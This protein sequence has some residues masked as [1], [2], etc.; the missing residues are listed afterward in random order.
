MKWGGTP[1]R[2]EAALSLL[3]FAI[4]MVLAGLV[5]AAAANATVCRDHQLTCWKKA[6]R[7]LDAG[8]RAYVKQVEWC[9]SR[10]RNIHSADGVHHGRMQ[11]NLQTARAAGFARDPHLT[12]KFQQRVR[13]YRFAQRYGWSHWSCAS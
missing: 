10:A 7:S 2:R 8:T 13:A 3:A 1:E 5:L 11:F 4:V 9:E 12:S 6:W